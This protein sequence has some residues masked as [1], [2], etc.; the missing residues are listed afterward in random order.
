MSEN[1]SKQEI[2]MRPGESS[3]SISVVITDDLIPGEE[4]ET[5]SITVYASDRVTVLSKTTVNVT[6]L[7]NGKNNNSF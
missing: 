4:N 1:I 2:V 5:F 7:D 6:I 3:G